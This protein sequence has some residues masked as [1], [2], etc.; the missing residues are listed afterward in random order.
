MLLEKDV[1]IFTEEL[2]GNRRYQQHVEIYDYPLQS[3]HV[4]L[5]PRAS[6]E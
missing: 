6:F 5:S 4:S 1:A 3:K 2:K